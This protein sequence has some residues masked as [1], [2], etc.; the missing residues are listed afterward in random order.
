VRRIAGGGEVFAFRGDYVP[1]LRLHHAFGCADAVTDVEQ[2]IVVVVDDGHRRVGL[3]VDALVG[4]Q[5]AVIKSLEAHYRRVRGISGATILSDGS[6]A[7]I[8]DVAGVVQ[9]G[10]AAGRKAAA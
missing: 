10:N 3:L 1:I 9:I 4:Q 6:V 2:G 5:Q 7:L 8:I